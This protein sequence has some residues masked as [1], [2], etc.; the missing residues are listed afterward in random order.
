[1][2]DLEGLETEVA[3]GTIGRSATLLES[4]ESTMDDAR[5]AFDRGAATGHVVIADHQTRGR[6]SHGRV[7]QSPSG[8]GLYLSIVLRP[9][10]PMERLST[11]TL[12]VGLGVARTVDAFVGDG[13]ARVKW[14]NDV[15][16]DDAKCAGILVES[17]ITSHGVEGVIVGIGLN[18][19]RPTAVLDD[20]SRAT[21]IGACLGERVD[22]RA[23]AIRLF[24]ELDAALATWTDTGLS[25][26]LTEL[27]DRLA[28]RG[29]DVRLDDVPGV[30]VGVAEDGSVVLR[31]GTG[32]Q[33]FSAGRITR[34]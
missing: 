10:V 3:S 15:L 4:T 13:R 16:V 24:A 14:P 31:T 25:E 21:S 34:R 33:S 30:L 7:W 26:L 27:V 5:A 19:N 6:G 20:G 11:M 22:R 18:C 8:D 9:E 2:R 12:A 23:I 17:R 1:M 32:V 29:E 28:F